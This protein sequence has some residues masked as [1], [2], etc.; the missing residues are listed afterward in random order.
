MPTTVER[1]F[2][3]HGSTSEIANEIMFVQRTGKTKTT[4]KGTWIRCLVNI[5]L[6]NYICLR[7]DLS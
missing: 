7:I 2:A 6:L 3:T 1:R 4:Q 5:L